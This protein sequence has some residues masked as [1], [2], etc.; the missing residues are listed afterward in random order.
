MIH[1]QC[2]QCIKND[3][4]SF[5][6]NFKLAI[7]NMSKVNTTVEDKKILFLVDNNSIHV[8]VKCKMF[9]PNPKN[10]PIPR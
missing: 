7:Y 5:Q 4:C 3:V 1:I 9:Y 2:E 8:E 10:A 6:P